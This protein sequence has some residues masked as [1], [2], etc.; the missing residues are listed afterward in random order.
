MNKYFRK[1]SV[2][3]SH[4]A[5]IDRQQNLNNSQFLRVQS[6]YKTKLVRII[7]LVQP[8]LVP[9]IFR[10][11]EWEEAQGDCGS[12]PHILIRCK[13]LK[14]VVSGTPPHQCIQCLSSLDPYLALKTY[15]FK[16]KKACP[17]LHM[18]LPPHYNC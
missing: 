13:P 15:D 4:L 17:S 3:M 18:Y 9:S 14:T 6:S 2:L 7:E 10:G 5:T 1:I 8:S 16:K 11:L 12:R